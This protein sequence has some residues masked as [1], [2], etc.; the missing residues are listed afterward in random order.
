[1]TGPRC[2]GRATRWWIARFRRVFELFDLARIDHFRAFAAYWAVPADAE[3]ALR[4]VL[5]ARPGRARR[6]TPPA[7]RW[8]S[9]R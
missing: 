8:A 1:M 6:S 4:G 7:R 2:G 5:E 3:C 9:C